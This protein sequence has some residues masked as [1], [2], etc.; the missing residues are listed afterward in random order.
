M[1]NPME[2]V[3]S[4]FMNRGTR[5]ATAVVLVMLV[6]ATGCAERAETEAPVEVARNVRVL[7]MQP[8]DLVEFF[9]ISGPLRP[10]RG[11]DVSSEEMGVVHAIP[12]DKGERVVEGNVIVEL[13]R[14]ILAAD[15]ASA[16]DNLKLQTHT[17]A[18]IATL[19]EAGK[20]SETELLGA[21][22]TKAQAESAYRVAQLRY[23]RA[24]VKAP[25]D[26]VFVDRQVELG[27]L[28]SPGQAVGRVIDPYV[29]KLAGTVSEREVGWLRIDA[30]ATVTLEGMGRTVEG[31]VA[32]I[33]F[34]ADPVTGKFKVEVHVDNA[35]LA[36]RAGVVARARI[37]K[38]THEDVLVAPRD[39]V[40]YTVY[41]YVVY[42][43]EGDRALRREVETGPDQGLMI[44][45]E[46]GLASGDRLVV[47]GQRDLIDGA[48]VDVTEQADA[49]DGSSDGDPSEVVEAASTGGG[50]GAGR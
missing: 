22:A 36:L 4:E 31:K 19:F 35:D 16:R 41:G 27:Q 1:N 5:A 25:F 46:Q 47:R 23:E 12:H 37:H 2:R 9:E 18:S 26:G 45:I 28:V 32:W 44:V 10:V 20:V 43:V 13:D 39:A 29:L 34:E 17:A 49:R 15:M 6:L 40:M 42:V 33:G 38:V 21:E 7:E 48:L 50:E 24:A 11:T 8:T 3:M 14:R 30:S